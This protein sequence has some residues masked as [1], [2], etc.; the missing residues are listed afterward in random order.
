MQ[1]HPFAASGKS[2]LFVAMAI[3]IAVLMHG[4]LLYLYS[5]LPT[6]YVLLDAVFAV[7]LLFLLG[8]V[9]WYV[10]DVIRIIQVEVVL[11]VVILCLWIFVC[12]TFQWIAKPLVDVSISQLL[13]TAPLRLFIGAAFWVILLL[14]YHLVKFRRWKEDRIATDNVQTPLVK[15]V[16][17]IAVK[18]GSRIH[19]IPV[20]D[21]SYVQACGDYVML[22]TPM[23]EFLKEQTMKS[24]EQYL[25]S[26]FLRVHRS[27]IVNIEQIERVELFAKETYHVHLKNGTF[28]RA[29][30]AGY[31]LLKGCFENERE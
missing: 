24:L 13:Y 8:Y 28:V 7:G 16:D 12:L 14:G 15:V 6:L 30:L 23:G 31:K 1:K 2:S 19:V 25:P 27:F 17:R 4:I 3:L 26:N 22:F 18:N 20:K 29:S 10:T 9:F 11:S 5:D 21:I